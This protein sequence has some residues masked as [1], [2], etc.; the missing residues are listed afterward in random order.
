MVRLNDGQRRLL[1]DKLSNVA[2]IAAAALV[3][4]Q[5]LGQGPFSP[6]LAAVGVRL[7]V[8]LFGCALYL[9]GGTR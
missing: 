4:G 1:A 8:F 3:F 2:N 9:T 5:A 6:A 7:W